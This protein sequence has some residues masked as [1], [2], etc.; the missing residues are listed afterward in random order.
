MNGIGASPGYGIGPVLIKKPFVL[1]KKETI[2][3]VEA[4][5]AALDEAV[6]QADKAIK[7]IMAH[8]VTTM[9]QSEGDIFQAHLMMLN[10]PELLNQIREK[11]KQ[12][13][14][15]AYATLEVRDAF[16][17]I[18]ESMDNDYMRERKADI[19]DVCNRLMGIL[20]GVKPL[21]LALIQEPVILVAHDLTPSDTASIS[22]DKVAGFITEI[23]GKTSHTAIMARTMELPAIVGAG[24]FIETLTGHEILM[25]DGH[26]GEITLNPSPAKQS[27]YR[28][29][30]E[31]EKAEKMLLQAFVGQQTITED[32]HQ[33]ELA[34]NIGKPED[35]SYVQQNDGEGI[36]LFRSEF[37]YMDREAMPSEEEQYRAYKTVLEAMSGKPVVIRTLD[38]GGDKQISYLDFPKEE[39]PFLGYRAI[40][41]CLDHEEIFKVQLRA[42]VRASLHGQLKIMFPMIS[43]IRE[44]RKAKGMIEE[45]KI[46]LAEENIAYGDFEVG[47]MIEIPAAA[48]ISDQLAKEVD[49]FSIGTNDL[50]Q[51]T[52]AVDRMNERIADLYSPYHPALLRLIKT[53]I[54]NGHQAGI[55]VGMCGEVA[56]NEKLMPLLLAMGLDEF[57]MSPAMILKARKLIHGLSY[58]GL[59]SHVEEILNAEDAYAVLQLLDS[60]FTTPNQ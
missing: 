37:L 52:T 51:Y 30:I 14:T 31:K 43:N 57:S 1:P 27:H 22:K 9:G 40:R 16:I 17:A 45:V 26:T 24:D 15:P 21:D 48:I 23:G 46:A 39:N 54:D 2:R 8:A 59:Q 25:I 56:G 3:D 10:D 11:I 35:V 29:L 4:G 6:S 49:F 50:I 34:C 55:W 18:F 44:I 28:H 47:I 20:M 38:V 7:S 60:K 53:V 36:G 5:L 12:K 33:V 32:G 41:Y 42:L 19:K 58:T 13:L